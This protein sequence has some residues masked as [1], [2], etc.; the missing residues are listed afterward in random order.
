MA[1]EASVSKY[2]IILPDYINIVPASV[3]LI[4]GRIHERRH[5]KKD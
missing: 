2:T 4:R 5:K 1:S 3:G